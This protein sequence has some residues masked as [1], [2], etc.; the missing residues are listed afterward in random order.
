MLTAL[1]PPTK[2]LPLAT[3]GVRNGAPPGFCQKPTEV[4]NNRCERSPAS[5][6]Y[7]MIGSLEILPGRVVAHTIPV[8]GVMPFEDTEGIVP[9]SPGNVFDDAEAS[10]REGDGLRLSRYAFSASPV[11]A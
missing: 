3:V 7:I 10:V 5:Y 11:S 2:T 6:A 1:A 9:P 4:R 8:C